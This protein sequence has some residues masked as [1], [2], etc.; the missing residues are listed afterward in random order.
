MME[1]EGPRVVDYFVVSGLSEASAPLGQEVMF[2]DVCH[3]AAQT[4]LPITDVIVLMRSIG[5]DVP[6]GYTC[7]EST[8]SG[9]SA[10]L[11]NGS[12]MAPQFYICY[13]RGRDRAPLTDLG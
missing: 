6:P 5:E 2:D 10:D 11:N 9:L 12:L 8:P 1:D 13:R 4:K 7:V 3:K